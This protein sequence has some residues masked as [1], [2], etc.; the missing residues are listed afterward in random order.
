MFVLTLLQTYSDR[1]KLEFTCHTAF[2]VSIVIVQW[3][4]LIICKT[5][6]N[7][8]VHQGMK[9]VNYTYCTYWR[10]FFKIGKNNSNRIF[11]SLIGTGSLTSVWCSKLVWLLCCH[12]VLEWT[13][14]FECTHSSKFSSHQFLILIWGILKLK[15]RFALLIIVYILYRINWWIPA[16][17][18]SL[19]IFIYDEIRRFIL[20]R[21]P[22]GWVEQ[23]T[24]Y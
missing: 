11:F 23:E 21:N 13:L 24:Y 15:I 16:M 18:F 19:A 10:I 17:P 2:F 7:S 4:D 1:K 3:A 12:T 22:G 5:R 20:R 6:R 14:L 8:I 9:Y